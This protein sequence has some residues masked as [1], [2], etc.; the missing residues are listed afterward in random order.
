MIW[1]LCDISINNNIDNT[2]QLVDTHEERER[3]CKGEEWNR[4]NNVI[5]DMQTSLLQT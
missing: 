1:K 3:K 4:N 2:I 5:K